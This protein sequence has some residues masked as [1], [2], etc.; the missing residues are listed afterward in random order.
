MHLFCK[1]CSTPSPGIEC[2]LHSHYSSALMHF[3]NTLKQLQNPCWQH[4]WSGSE[5]LRGTATAT[6]EGSTQHRP[7]QLLVSYILSV[8]YLHPKSARDSTACSD[9][10]TNWSVYLRNGW[11]AFF[12]LMS[13]NRMMYQHQT[14]WLLMTTRQFSLYFN[15]KPWNIVLYV[16]LYVWCFCGFKNNN[17]TLEADRGFCEALQPCLPSV[18]FYFILYFRHTAHSFISEPAHTGVPPWLLN[19]ATTDS[20]LRWCITPLTGGAVGVGGSRGEGVADG[21]KGEKREKKKTEGCCRVLPAKCR[22]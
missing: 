1:K 5:S 12:K 20:V 4:E 13:S 17:T 7:N 11:K 2:Y 14:A 22:R 19:E 6:T 9:S 21:L 8:Q 15:Y 10:E 16:L 3:N 18:V